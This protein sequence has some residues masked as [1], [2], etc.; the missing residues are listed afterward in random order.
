MQ[1]YTD[2]GEGDRN[3]KIGSGLFVKSRQSAHRECRSR[4][5]I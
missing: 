3:E 2:R 1:R 5:Q 4:E